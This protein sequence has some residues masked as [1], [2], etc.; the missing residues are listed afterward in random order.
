MLIISQIKT[1]NLFK[2]S[3][4]IHLHMHDMM[5]VLVIKLNYFVI[6]FTH[7]IQ[8]HVQLNDSKFTIESFFSK[9]TYEAQF[10]ND[11]LQ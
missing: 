5:V 1:G 9:T 10:L 8:L 4:L 6:S 11:I 2:G 7:E 3:S